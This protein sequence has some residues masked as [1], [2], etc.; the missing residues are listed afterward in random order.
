MVSEGVA[1]DA[2]RLQRLGGPGLV[3]QRLLHREGALVGRERR[4]VV[5]DPGLH[6]ADPPEG[7]RGERSLAR[8]LR[9]PPRAF[10]A[11]ER[12]APVPEPAVDAAEVHQRAGHARPVPGRLRQLERPLEMLERERVAPQP[13]VEPTDVVVRPRER[14]RVAVPLADRKPSLERRPLL[15]A[16][17]APGAR[18]L[19]AREG[20]PRGPPEPLRGVRG[21][22]ERPR[23]VVRSSDRPK[24][25]TANE[26]Q[27]DSVTSAGEASGAPIPPSAR[28][29]LPSARAA[30]PATTRARRATSS[31]VPR[32][33]ATYSDSVPTLSR[34]AARA[35]ASAASCAP[36]A[37][38]SSATSQGSRSIL[39]ASARQRFD[40]RRAQ[41]RKHR[42]GR[43]DGR[44]GRRNR[45]GRGGR[46]GRR[47]DR[48]GRRPVVGG[49][50]AAEREQRQQGMPDPHRTSPMGS[51]YARRPRP[52]KGGE[53]VGVRDVPTPR[54]ARR[55]VGTGRASV[56]ARAP[57]E[58]RRGT[59]SPR[60]AYRIAR[61]GY[62]SRSSADSNRMADQSVNADVAP[63]MTA[64]R[65]HGSPLA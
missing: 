61:R 43:L 56:G 44:R 65:S 33:A 42:V 17:G 29:A 21:R 11:R 1:D 48:A 19:A 25:P 53:T 57:R 36:L 55:D 52:G 58:L 2:D 30:V 24:R 26:R 39:A 12:V 3:V 47:T 37:R 6:V 27:A 35:N 59:D 14:R 18:G 10:E 40:R 4:R 28:S 31:G 5:S 46:R 50:E 41:R 15:G 9:L 7:L 60:D 64:M 63:R 54:D 45:G 23:G 20:G 32:H 62:S 8:G 49:R 38:S 34:G 51:F 13:R 16:C 22:D